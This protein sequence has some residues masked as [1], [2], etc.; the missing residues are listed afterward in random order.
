MSIATKVVLLLFTTATVATSVMLI[1][2][3]I[4]VFA[5]Q[6]SIS[7]T[8]IESSDAP[9]L[10]GVWTEPDEWSNA[11]ETFVNYTDGSRLV[12][13]TLHDE[14]SVFILLEMPDDHLVD[15]HAL[16][17]FDT[18]HDGGYNLEP[19][20]YCF[21]LGGNAREYRGDGYSKVGQQRDLV[22]G[23][24]IERGLSGS[25][26]PY[27]E[28]QNHVTYEYKIP[29][30]YIGRSAEY[31][32]WVTFD[33]PGEVVDKA[34]KYYWPESA[35]GSYF[36]VAPPREWGLLVVSTVAPG[37]TADGTV[38]E[39]PASVMAGVAA[40]GLAILFARKRFG[41]QFKNL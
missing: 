38:P 11:V 30:D 2:L 28:V 15:G 41:R 10:D 34:A 1:Y 5:Q 13:R 17:C 32:F 24:V 36:K 22:G 7:P 25:N 23:V 4:L 27:Y 33:S 8:L 9:I 20:D 16:V 37:T 29:L 40:I 26:S 19:D 12:V 14:N 6:P 18:L 39:F 35:R 31:G 21:A 3:P